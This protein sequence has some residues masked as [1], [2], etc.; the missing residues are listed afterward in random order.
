M[1]ALSGEV[2]LAGRL[3]GSPELVEACRLAGGRLDVQACVHPDDP[4]TASA[5]LPIDF[6]LLRLSLRREKFMDAL[7]APPR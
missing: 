3:Y 5:L 7:G 4:R 1:A 2:R 6:R